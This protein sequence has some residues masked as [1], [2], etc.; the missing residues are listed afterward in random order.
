RRSLMLTH[1]LVCAKHP[2][3]RRRRRAIFRFLLK[4]GFVSIAPENVAALRSP[5]VLLKKQRAGSAC[6]DKGEA[7]EKETSP[8]VSCDLEQTVDVAVSIDIDAVSGRFFAKTRHGHDC[9]GEGN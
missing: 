4:T 7:P 1:S 5:K 6:P 8:F 2:S 9:T 3:L